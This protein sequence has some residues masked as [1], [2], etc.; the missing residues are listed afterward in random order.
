M[1]QAQSKII[2]RTARLPG[3]Q[4]DMF[5][6]IFQSGGGYVLDFSN[7]R[8]SEWFAEAF[9][10]NIYQERF[11]RDGTSKARILRCFVEVAEPR[12]VATACP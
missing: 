1:S 10:I 7:N 3:H 4:K 12:L 6:R 2:G 5:D 11:Q 9:D 8:M